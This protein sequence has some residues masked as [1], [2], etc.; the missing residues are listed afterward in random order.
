MAPDIDIDMVQLQDIVVR[1]KVFLYRKSSL[2]EALQ[3]SK[4]HSYVLSRDTSGY[5]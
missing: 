4:I 2:L 3:K 1:P 5:N